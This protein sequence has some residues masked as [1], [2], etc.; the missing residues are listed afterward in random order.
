MRN[1]AGPHFLPSQT[2]VIVAKKGGSAELLSGPE[3]ILEFR[4]A[5][6]MTP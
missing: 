3:G 2:V 6:L 5:G 1:G 4:S